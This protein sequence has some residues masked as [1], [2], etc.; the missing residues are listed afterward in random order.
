MKFKEG[1]FCNVEK[2][3]R[4]RKVLGLAFRR[5]LLTFGEKNFNREMDK[6]ARLQLVKMR[7]LQHV[8][9]ALDEK[10]REEKLGNQV[11]MDARG[12]LHKVREDWILGRRGSQGRTE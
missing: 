12:F 11:E 5:S 8:E 4:S 1:G 6:E 3:I 7:T 10:E 9:H 2:S